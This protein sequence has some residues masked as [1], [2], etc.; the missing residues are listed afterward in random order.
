MSYIDAIIDRD[1]DR[2]H[3]VER[4]NGK[5]LY[6]EYPAS[7]VFYYDDPR[8]K[9]RTIYDTP[10]TRFAT[11]SSKEFRRELKM[12]EGKRLWESDINPVFKRTLLE[13][14]RT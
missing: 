13:C 3:V 4:V 12:H 9:H 2:I 14:R 7:Y 1:T 10:V 6:N 5:R 8:G 11:R